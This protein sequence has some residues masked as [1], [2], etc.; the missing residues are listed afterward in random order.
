MGIVT[1]SAKLLVKLQGQ[2]SSSVELQRDCFT[3][4]R[5]PDND[6]LIE[7]HTVSSHHARITRVQSVYFLEDLKSTNGTTVNGQAVE[8]AQLHDADVIA[9][10]QHR[11]IFQDSGTVTAQASSSSTGFDQTMAIPRKSV[12][13]GPSIAAR[14]LV[15]AGK[16]DHL[17]Y[18]L[19]RPVNLIGSQDGAAIRLTGWFAPKTAALI[20][21]R[22]GGFTVS[23]SQPNKPLLV[24]GKPVTVQQQLKDGDVIEVAGV[25]MTFY[26]VQP[27]AR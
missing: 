2:S 26:V 16:T 25:S 9:I 13:G 22:A 19:N 18:Q 17:E 24:N 1:N 21:V 27:K 8:R 23:P 6:L 11:I 4:G 15:T 20:S 10:G 12:Q 3:I 14:I 5:K 7:D